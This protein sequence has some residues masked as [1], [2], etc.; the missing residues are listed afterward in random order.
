MKNDIQSLKAPQLL[1]GI[2]LAVVLIGL[3][4][5]FRNAYYDIG[6]VKYYFYC[7]SSI[8]LIPILLFRLKERPSIRGFLASLSLGEKALLVYWIVSALS[9][10]CSPYRF[11]AFWGNE[12][13]LSGLFLM[14]IYVISYFSIARCYE[15][16]PFFLYACALSGILVFALGITD[17]FNL[18]L[19]HFKDHITHQQSMDFIS[20][21]GN[22]NFYV[23]YG[24]VIV[25]LSAG[26]Y[27]SCTRFADAWIWFALMLFSFIGL[28]IGNSDSAYL[29]FGVLVG[30]LPFC[31]FRSRRGARRYLMMISALLLAFLL[32]KMASICFQGMVWELNGVPAILLKWDGF[33]HL[34]LAVW[35]L[36]AGWYGRDYLL[37]RQD[38]ALD[39]KWRIFWWILLFLEAAA[40]L[41][42][43]LDANVMGHAE[44]YGAVRNYVVFDQQW[45]THRG[46][47]WRKAVENYSHFLPLQKI[48]GLGPDTYGIISYFKNLSESGGLFGELFDSVHNEYL[49]FF[50]TIGPIATGA[51]LL[52][53]GASIR[54]MLKDPGS[55]SMTGIAFGVACYCGQALVSINQ[56]GGTS[57]MWTILAMGIAESRK[58]ERRQGALR[59]SKTFLAP[60]MEPAESR[61]AGPG[62]DR[63]KQG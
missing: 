52:F 45:G 17:F 19:L 58:T 44:R 50:V 27:T 51:Y 49:Q 13:R 53:L 37:H 32:V 38:A 8:L 39:G 3:P 28:I 57:I 46:F 21:M 55:P 61:K 15:P 29:T 63:W 54:D 4:L 10:L 42:V 33:L 62:R 41:A 12:G 6:D 22:I 60:N 7:G 25:G 23:S 43:L 48:L 47:V 35:A 1:T 30:F 16:H 40:I 56:P 59:T 14:S 11:E 9:T 34:C 2:Y 18:N 20:T 24:A 5:C 26:M 31:L 36:T